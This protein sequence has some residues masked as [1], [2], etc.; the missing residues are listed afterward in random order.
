[1]YGG[2]AFLGYLHGVN[3]PDAPAAVDQNRNQSIES[4]RELFQ[5]FIERFEYTD[6]QTLTGCDWSKEED[7]R[8]YREEKV[9]EETCFH[10]FEY[11]LATCLARDWVAV[12]SGQWEPPDPR[13]KDPEKK[14]FGA[15]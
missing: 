10:Y 2:T 5:G 4:V 15:Q 14:Y 6:C 3:A 8:R 12:E 11:V 13:E 1:L 9:Y 7:V